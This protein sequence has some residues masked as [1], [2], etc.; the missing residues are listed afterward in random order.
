MAKQQRKFEKPHW[1][2]ERGLRDSENAHYYLALYVGFTRNFVG[3]GG[4]QEMLELADIMKKAE[5]G[6]SE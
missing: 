3:A 1:C 5:I 6:V 4:K 2:V